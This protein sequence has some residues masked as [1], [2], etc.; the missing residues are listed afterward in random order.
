MCGSRTKRWSFAGS[1]DGRAR[2]EID[3]KDREP[4][5][6]AECGQTGTASLTEW[7]IQG[8]ESHSRA[9][10]SLRYGTLGV[11]KGAMRPSRDPAARQTRHRQLDW[12]PQ[13]LMVSLC[14]GWHEE[15]DIVTPTQCQSGAALLTDIEVWTLPCPCVQRAGR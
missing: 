12:F 8:R 15:P 3:R 11:S 9:G 1:Y 14:V 7:E 10:I 2:A 5:A 4:R 13:Q 6:C